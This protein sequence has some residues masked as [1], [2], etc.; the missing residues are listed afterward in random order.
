ML[1]ALIFATLLY[2]RKCPMSLSFSSDS[3]S[4]LDRMAERY[5][6]KQPLVMPALHMAQKEFGHLSDEALQLVAA[7]L[8]LPYPH[9]YGVAT[10][11]TMYKREPSG[12]TT[13]RVCTNVSCMLRGAYDV[14]DSLTSKLG[15]EVG[16]S[17]EDFHVV[18]EECIAKCANAPAILAGTK[19]FLDLEPK[20]VDDMLTYLRSN[21]H[22]ESEVA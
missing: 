10:F 7:T 14:L 2:K 20:D 11:Y 8:G 9:V 21:P 6:S 12:K 4:K 17:T 16:G 5:P 19:Y 22:P 18:E 3:L 1:A 15:V 13:L